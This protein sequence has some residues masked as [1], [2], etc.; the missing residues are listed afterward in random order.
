[1]VRKPIDVATRET[2]EFIRAH[3]APGDRVLEV[4]CGRGEVAHALGRRIVA[5]KRIRTSR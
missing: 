4:G 3:S 1:M 2:V 5:R